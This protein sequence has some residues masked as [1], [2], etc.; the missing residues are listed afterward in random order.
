VSLR[1][2]RVL[3]EVSEPALVAAWGQSL[4]QAG[5]EVSC[6]PGPGHGSLACPLLADGRCP[7]VDAASVV[8]HSL[9]GEDAERVER[10][11]E[12]PT[13]ESPELLV[14]PAHGASLVD[15]VRKLS[16]VR[17]RRRRVSCVVRGEPVVVRAIEVDDA[18]Q[19][20]AFDAQLSEQS[21]R[22]RYLGYMPA[23]DPE[24]ARY[25]TSVDFDSRFALVAVTLDGSRI[26]ADCRLVPSGDGSGEVAI[27][28][29]DDHQGGGL[30]E[31]MLELVLGIAA[32]RGLQSVTAEVRYDNERM[33]ALLRRLGFRRTA[34]EL[35]IVSLACPLD[36]KPHVL[37]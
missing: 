31:S 27:A 21:R 16:A 15:G 19:Y 34:W 9:D 1:R 22:L 37:T 10:A 13:S 29:A 20:G 36:A 30:G 2:S 17:A 6:C 26:V 3:L 5:F 28:V 7:L 25:L 12:K 18:E 23:L 8:V 35:G 14:R 32:D 4:L 33:L 11:L 24:R